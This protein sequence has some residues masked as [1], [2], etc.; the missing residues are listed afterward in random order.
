MPHA[1]KIVF[2]LGEVAKQIRMGTNLLRLRDVSYVVY[3]ILMIG[4]EKVNIFKV[5]GEAVDEMTS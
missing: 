1:Y 2:Q 4:S 3:V 5:I